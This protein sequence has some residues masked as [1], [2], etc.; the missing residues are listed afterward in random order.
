M[1]R[2][3]A[4]VL[5]PILTAYTEGKE[6]QVEI[7]GKWIDIKNWTLCEKLRIKPNEQMQILFD[8]QVSGETIQHQMKSDEWRDVVI[9][10]Q[11]L[12][13]DASFY[14]IKPA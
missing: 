5:L 7:N 14:R 13:Y 11:D 9:T 12:N 8:A 10:E 6:I 3:D 1:N 2:D 4:K